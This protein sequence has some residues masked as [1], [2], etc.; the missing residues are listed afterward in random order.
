VSGAIHMPGIESPGL[1]AFGSLRAEDEP[2]LG[3]CFVPPPEFERITGDNSVIVFGDPGS[4]K[5]ALYRQLQARSQPAGSRSLRLVADWQPAPLSP[6]AR[7][8]LAWVKRQ[9][10]QILAACAVALARHLASSPTDYTNSSEWVQGRLIWFIRRFILGDPALRLG[11]LTEGSSEG[12]ALIRAILTASVR[13]VLYE[14]ASP[15]EVINELLGALNGLGLGGLWVMTDGL[16]GWMEGDPGALTQ[17]LRA[18]LSTLE[19][20]EH[21]ALAYKVFLPSHLKP[22][23]SRAIGPARRR[24]DQYNLEWN[25]SL[26]EQVVERRTALA[27]EKGKLRLT[28]LCSAPDL[29]PWLEKVGGTS[30]R[31]WLDQVQPLVKY[32]L[33]QHQV[34][35]IDEGTWKQLR[36]RHPPRLYLDD[37]ARR[38][39]VGGRE[40]SLEDLPAK[41][42]DMLRY[43][44]QHGGKVVSKAELYFLA[45]R[46]LKQIPRS[47]SDK[48]YEPP[49]D[50]EGVVD[51]NLWRLR[52]A[53]EPDPSNP[54]L[55]VTKR[56]YGVVLQARW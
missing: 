32:Y 9:A 8:D 14:D 47:Q 41:A 29:L 26:L 38:V 15:R 34:Q 44:Y 37:A 19:L 50:Y 52:K 55:L 30:P 4:G 35:A 24:L 10:M 45:Y 11:P 36:L 17:E 25:V 54:V 31:E 5:T 23:L 49:K 16:E 42:F 46:E 33:S 28:D 1:N 22:D 53:I 40:V 39:I 2:W 27:I 18:F 6:T 3:A 7:P 43:L 51:T 56:G 21:A 12:A 13:D 48:D 20:F